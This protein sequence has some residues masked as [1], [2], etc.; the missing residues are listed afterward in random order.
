MEHIFMP[1]VLLKNGYQSQGKLFHQD[2]I[3]EE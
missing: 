1:R 3:R 2:P